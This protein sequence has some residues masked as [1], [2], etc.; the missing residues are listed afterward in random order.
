[1]YSHRIKPL[2][3][4]MLIP[5]ALMGMDVPV[6]AGS[7][8]WEGIEVLDL[9][10]AKKI[11]LSD[12]PSMA[13]ALLRVEQAKEVVRQAKS[14]YFPRL[15]A[16]ASASLVELSDHVF[17]DN[18]QTARFFNPNA[19]IEDPQDYYKAG[20]VATWNLFDGFSRRFAHA[21]ARHGETLSVSARRDTKRL[22]LSS[23]AQ[24]FYAAQLALEG[25]SI[26]EADEAF[27]RHQLSEA[28]AR[29][30]AGTGSLSEELNFQV[31]RNAATA[32]RLTAAESYKAA[33]IGLATLMGIPD[34]RFPSKV[35]LAPLKGETEEEMAPQD[36]NRLQDIA[37]ESRPDLSQGR[38]VVEQKKAEIGIARSGFYPSV[39]LTANLTGDR[40]ADARFQKDDFGG[41]VAVSFS[42]NIFDGGLVRAKVAGARAGWSEAR[43]NLSSLE[44]QVNREVQ[45]A[46]VELETAGRQLVLQ[47]RN[48][49]LVKQTRDLVE[50]EYRAGQGSLV[51]LNEAQRD[52]ITA[53]SRLA[54]ALVGLHQ[55]WSGLQTATGGILVGFED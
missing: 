53:Q 34:A 1:M 16:A 41:S 55:A 14:A 47:R 33:M 42:Y 35:A 18:L 17:E 43:Q 19:D 39:D 28:E 30:R 40:E 27:N 51:R 23:V 20:I 6:W 22:L 11:T 46:V 49:D 29:R 2:I 37:H 15:D 54:L 5:I 48:T 50:K 31:R 32:N 24:A 12:N 26:A 25:V 44:N 52:L 8:R 38:V 21:A 4:A 7:D 13:A 3:F 45:E 10:T 36:I 9:A